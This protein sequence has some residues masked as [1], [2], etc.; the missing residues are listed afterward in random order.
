MIFSSFQRP[1]RYIN[2]E[3]NSIR[4]S[5]AGDEK[6]AAG[7]ARFVLAFPD[8]Y[9][10]GMSHLGLKILYDIINGLPYACSERCFAP[11]PDL[12]AH[13]KDSSLL[14]PALES[15]APIRDFDI[16]GFSL[17][18]ELSYTTVLNMLALGGMPLRTAERMDVKG[19]LPLV[20]AGGPCTV[21]PAP[22]AP[23]IDAFLVGDGEN[24]AV[25]LAHTVHRWKVEGDGRRETL[26]REIAALDGFYV[27][28]LHGPAHRTSRL[29]VDDL[30]A[31]AYP[32]K[33]VVPY[34]SIVHDRV[35][36][37]V[38]R[39]CPMGCRFCQ[40]GII[41][42]PLRERSPETILRIAAEAL[43]NTGHDEVSLTSL[44]AGDY[45]CLLPVIRE[46]NKKF[47][48]S[49]IALS[50]PS[51][52]VKAIERSVLKEIRSVR[53]TGFT[54]APEAA[55]D[56]LRSVINK[57]FTNED[58]ERAL[59]TLFGEGWLNL[60]L[61]FMTG[62]PTERDEDMEAIGQMATAALKIAKKNT[63]KFVNIGI[64]VSPFVP[65]AHTPFQWHG[66]DG[67]DEIRRKLHYLKESLSSRKFKYKGH[68]ERMSFLEAA[69]ARGDENLS[70][71]IAKAWE[72]GCRLDGW[73]EHFNFPAWSEAM[74]KTGID[75]AAYSQRSFGRDERLPWDII[76][77]GVRKDFLY[78]EYE[79]ALSQEKSPGCRETC[80]HCGLRCAGNKDAE[81]QRPVD[82]ENVFSSSPCPRVPVSPCPKVR[83][84]VRFTKMGRLRYLSHLEMMT[85]V[86]RGLRRA[87]VRFDFS[88]GFHPVPR[89]SFGP[90]LSVG[91]AGEREYFDMEVFSPFAIESYMEDINR[92]M[93]EDMRIINMG[94]VPV[95]EPS[96]NTF[97]TRYAYTIKRSGTEALRGGAPGDRRGI[98]PV[99][100]RRDGK[101]VDIA[102]CIEE[103]AIDGDI[104]LVL[105]DRD[106]LKVRLGE[107][108]EA[109]FGLNF[110]ETD[111]TR[112]AL[113][114]WKN[115]WIE[116]L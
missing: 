35:N 53:K 106:T 65:K 33:P 43:S 75:C 85:A 17:Q 115:G 72:F 66:Q 78:G 34:T 93:P 105:R 29:V 111:I 22:M 1:S 41:Y 6:K 84:R 19:H 57:D 31:A 96:L 62:L 32:V 48:G 60:K 46:F 49:R 9:E 64:T 12:E 89:V 36:I 54:I 79:R 42:R 15:H 2:S 8:T 20:I 112:N 109:L 76:N 83:V 40:A 11:W 30:D 99:I 61:Y 113:Y 16:V 7:R 4:P 97:I 81:T 56:R 107:V 37:E 114:G 70:P 94:L 77:V 71:L 5:P 110:R 100:V 38:S 88:K 63:G 82:A 55:T 13:M 86:V 14:L 23:Y 45:T 18:Y 24:A 95:N 26:L 21:N 44:S 27:P 101:E 68:D 87:G 28:V 47:S 102:P 51:L 108:I 90:S 3:Y 80:L 103:V 67:L 92:S 58:Y 74:D 10:I 25:S 50:L 52:R 73:S 116:P 59:E 104:R 91:V 39:G 98:S 69:F